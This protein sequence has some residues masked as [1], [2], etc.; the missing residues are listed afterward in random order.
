MV[1][2]DLKKWPRKSLQRKGPK[3]TFRHFSSLDQIPGGPIPGL[4]G[5]V[6][7]FLAF[8][9]AR[10]TQAAALLQ[11]ALAAAGT[12]ASA[13][14]AGCHHLRPVGVAGLVPLPGPALAYGGIALDAHR[15]HA[16]LEVGAG[17]AGR[18]VAAAARLAEH[19]KAAV[20]VDVYPGA[21]AAAVVGAFSG[22][23]LK[24]CHGFWFWL[25]GWV[26][27]ARRFGCGF[28][29]PPLAPPFPGGPRSSFDL[30]HRPV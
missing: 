13:M 25:K 8:H 29:R 2:A 3:S 22:C 17:L 15:Q 4:P 26:V 28:P 18:Q 21:L 6:L 27:I 20:V 14:G 30:G 9:P 11:L 5:C 24:W 12:E 19:G 1:V 16:L 10:R 7:C 23:E